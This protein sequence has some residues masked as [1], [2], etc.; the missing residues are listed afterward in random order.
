MPRILMLVLTVAAL[1]LP[2]RAPAQACSMA[3]W[4][5]TSGAQGLSTGTPADDHRRFQGQCG[6]KVRA[7]STPRYLQDNSPEGE[8]L[9]FARF[10]VFPDELELGNTGWVDV[11]TAH[12]NERQPTLQLGLRLVKDGNGHALVLRARDGAGISESDPVPLSGGW[13][14]VALNWKQASGPANGSAELKI[15]GRTRAS[16]S[17]L[18]NRGAVI[19]MARLGASEM[20]AADG[21]LDFDAFV[22][23]RQTPADELV[24]GDATADDRI[25]AADLVA[26]VNE[27][28]NGALV[29]GQPDCNGDGRVAGDDLECL[30]RR[31]VAE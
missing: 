27:I 17:G 20:R 5:A 1:A 3:N 12:G 16:L 4:S 9:Y 6:L 14:G 28:N 18:D 29:E 8:T 26:I 15:D 23:N 7:G 11:F 30:A 10:Y 21:S 22:S 13:T 19:D 2:G 25:D 24:R 31:I